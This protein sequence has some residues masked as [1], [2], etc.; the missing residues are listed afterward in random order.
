MPALPPIV[1]IILLA[2]SGVAGLAS[3]WLQTQSPSSQRL[4][5]EHS[6]AAPLDRTQDVQAP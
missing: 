5:Q 1:L 2:L 6:Y 4:R 3:W